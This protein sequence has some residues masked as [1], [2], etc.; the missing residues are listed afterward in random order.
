MSSSGGSKGCE[1]ARDAATSKLCEGLE[2]AER[3]GMRFLI[4]YAHRLLGETTLEA[5]PE[6]AINHFT[7][8]IA[9]FQEIK[10]ENEL[11]MACA[12]YGRL[13]KKEGK[14]QEARQYL[15]RALEVFERLGT[16]IEPDKVRREL[17]E[18]PRG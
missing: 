17:D 15:S 7:K 2:L 16:L 12:G 4:G 13:H 18:L 5:N 8:G 11:A 3:T 6:Q 9:V 10:A 14:I 1:A